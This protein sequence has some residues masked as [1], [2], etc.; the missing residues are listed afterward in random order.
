[1]DAA[2]ALKKIQCHSFGLENRARKAAHL[3]DN[4]TSDYGSAIWLMDLDIG[5]RIDLAKDFRSRRGAGN[6]GWF[7]AN[8]V[9]DCLQPAGNE[10]LGGDIP[11]T[12]I[13]F[14]RCCDWIVILRVHGGAKP[15]TI[16]AKCK[17]VYQTPD[18]AFPVAL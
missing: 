17:R 6:N 10:K 12:D 11:F 1:C 7:L 16:P 4:V 15:G 3:K 14:K 5:R 18:V 2:E 13:F 8:D 9:P